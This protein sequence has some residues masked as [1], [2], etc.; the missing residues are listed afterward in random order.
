MYELM[1]KLEDPKTETVK[2]FIHLRIMIVLYLFSIIP[3]ICGAPLTLLDALVFGYGTPY[4]YY[5]YVLY[6]ESKNACQN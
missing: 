5:I 6:K 2:W 3:N 1:D 4:I